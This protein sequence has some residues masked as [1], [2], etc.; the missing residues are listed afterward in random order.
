MFVPCRYFR[1]NEFSGLLNRPL[2]QKRKSV[3]ALFVRIS[4][5]SGLSEPGL[6]NHHC[7]LKPFI[8][9]LNLGS[10]YLY[11]DLNYLN[12]CANDL[13]PFSNDLEIIYTN[14]I[15]IGIN[16]YTFVPI[17]VLRYKSFW[18]RI[19]KYI[20]LIWTYTAIPMTGLWRICQIIVQM[21][22]D[23]P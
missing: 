13:Y 20:E 19:L 4:E 14:D 16:I 2:V 6:T 17:F 10:N 11:L 12:L 23:L 8:I 21:Q 5:I 18:E 3:P 9:D 7:I 15:K 22:S 1:I